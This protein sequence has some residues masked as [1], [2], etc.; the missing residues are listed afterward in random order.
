MH[1]D[2]GG[3]GTARLDALVRD[4]AGVYVGTAGN[5]YAARLR[6]VARKHGPVNPFGDGDKKI[7]APGNYGPITGARS[8]CPNGCPLRP[9]GK[10]KCYG[11]DGNVGTHERRASADTWPKLAAAACAVCWAQATGRVARLHVSGDLMAPDGERFDGAYVRGLQRIGALFGGADNRTVAWTY[12][13]A[14]DDVVTATV[15]RRLRVAGIHVRQS[16]RWGSNGA[17]V[18]AFA[19]VPRL[20]V[21]TLLPLVKCPA[22][23]THNAIDCQR[24]TRCWTQPNEVIVFDPHGGSGKSVAARAPGPREV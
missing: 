15:R 10:A 1:N 5:A 24:C 13:H 16:D 23:L 8:S 2:V 21:A 12:T 19:N 17:V 22:Q 18:A 4:L 6:K 11:T 20:R 14:P 7:K 9:N 3:A